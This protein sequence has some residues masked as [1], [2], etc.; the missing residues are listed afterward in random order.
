MDEPNAQ[1]RALAD[2]V[3]K[4]RRPAVERVQRSGAHLIG[5]PVGQIPS[6][7]LRQ[8]P[9]CI[10]ADMA[11]PIALGDQGPVVAHREHLAG[12]RQLVDGRMRAGL[13][14]ELHEHH[15]FVEGPRPGQQRPHLRPCPVCS[16]HDVVDGR[17]AIP[18][19]HLMAPAGQ[20]ADLCRPGAPAHGPL[21]EGLQQDGPEGGA[22][23]LRP[24]ESLAVMIEQQRAGRGVEPV[25]L[26]LRPRVG[27]EF[28]LQ[29]GQAKRP[30]SRFHVQVQRTA[31][32]AMA[33]MRIALED[34]R[35]RTADLQQARKHQST[36]SAADDGD[37]R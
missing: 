17:V 9:A 37:A 32:R 6:G 36:R 13:E 22:I 16:D 31:L 2:H 33:R 27:E 30:L 29:A 10:A 12:P 19:D 14:A 20:R 5:W 18:G 24:L 11:A 26:V 7:A 21:V 23:D 25:A 28:R 34:R 8:T 3:R 1:Q 15:A 4:H 35:R